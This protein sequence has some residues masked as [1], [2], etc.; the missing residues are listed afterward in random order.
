MTQRG[1]VLIATPDRS[2]ASAVR[3]VL[4]EYAVVESTD[5]LETAAA[6]VEHRPDLIVL[7]AAESTSA[8]HVMASLRDDFRTAYTPVLHI[9]EATPGTGSLVEFFGANDDYVVAPVRANELRT[10]VR[11]ALLRSSLR[12]GMSPLTGLPGNVAVEEEIAIREARGEAFACLY[13]DLDGFKGF[14][15]RHGFVRGDEAIRFLAR[16]IDR[17]LGTCA[18]RE[19]FVGHLGGDDFVVL[20]PSPGAREVAA[21]IIETFE[22]RPYGCS[23][24][25]GIVERAEALSDSALV[26]EAA[27]RSKAAAKRRRGSAWAVYSPGDAI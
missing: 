27:A 14:N 9:V 8:A 5:L 11:L 16:S 17:A 2:L 15:D 18:P 3:S 21:K 22:E 10:R 25:I 6:V 4:D 23:V 24:S 13:V 26:G 19:S 1:R 20:T 7:D 12:R